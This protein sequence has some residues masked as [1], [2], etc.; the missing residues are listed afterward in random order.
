MSAKV[1]ELIDLARANGQDP[2]A[3]FEAI[4]KMMPLDLADHGA[5]ERHL[6]SLPAA[7]PPK[8][9]AVVSLVERVQSDRDAAEQSAAVD[10]A[11]EHDRLKAVNPFRAADL[12][13][14]RS[15]EIF[16]GRKLLAAAQPPD[17]GGPEA[18]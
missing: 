12:L 1:L 5:A 8:S 9:A 17:G 16:R 7:S 13:L 4:R 14:A 15:A 3:A 11:L 10:A 6:A 18:A 2:R